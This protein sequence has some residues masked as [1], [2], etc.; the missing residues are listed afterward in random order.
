MKANSIETDTLNSEGKTYGKSVAANFGPSSELVQSQSID[1]SNIPLQG[2]LG[3]YTLQI[4]S[5]EGG[6]SQVPHGQ[7]LN[8]GLLQSILAAI[9]QPKGSASGQPIIQFQKSLEQQ[10]FVT[11]DTISSVVE[12][13]TDAEIRH[14]TQLA[15][16]EILKTSEVKD[17]EINYPPMNGDVNIAYSSPS[18]DVQIQYSP[19]S[20]DQDIQYS[21]SSSDE[22]IQ[23]S[24]SSS[25][26]DTQYSSPTQY[27]ITASD[28]VNEDKNVE[29]NEVNSEDSETPVLQ[30]NGIALYF[31]NNQ[32]LKKETDES[33]TGEQKFEKTSERNE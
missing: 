2:A 18:S 17:S 29:N 22:T 1:F 4:Q 21:P 14:S 6:Q 30:D 8:D 7:V 9:E 10:N 13:L 19:S 20:S 16:D 3:S 11:N 26:Q 15:R 33:A 32:R 23:Y 5:A 25:D 27:I 24:S 28:D 31:N 12:Q